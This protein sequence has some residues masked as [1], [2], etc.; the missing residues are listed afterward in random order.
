MNRSEVNG[1]VLANIDAKDVEQLFHGGTLEPWKHCR[2]S[3]AHEMRRH[4]VPSASSKGLQTTHKISDT[5]DCRMTSLDPLRQPCFK[6][7][8]LTGEGM[9]EAETVRKKA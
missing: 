2:S 6:C 1:L 9:R 4:V 8:S 3:I 7:H 5:V